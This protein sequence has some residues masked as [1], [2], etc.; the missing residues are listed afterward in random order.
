MTVIDKDL[1]NPDGS[2][3]WQMFDQNVGQNYIAGQIIDDLRKWEQ[4][5][6]TAI[7]IP[8]ANTEK[9]ERLITDEVNANNVETTSLCELWLDEL[10]K[11]FEATNKMFGLGLSVEWRHNPHKQEVKEG[12]QNGNDT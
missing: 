5:F 6:D 3:A 1:F 4:R 11:S 8:N 9:K 2:P 10:E 12:G 7:G